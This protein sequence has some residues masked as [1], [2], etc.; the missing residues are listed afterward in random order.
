[1]CV[2]EKNIFY[3]LKKIIQR[4]GR[5]HLDSF[6]CHGF[7]QKKTS[8]YFDYVGAP[9]STV[10]NYRPVIFREIGSR[11]TDGATYTHT[12]PRVGNGVLGL[13][14]VEKLVWHATADL[15]GPFQIV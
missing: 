1:L 8:P 12:W 7:A 4:K 2:I 14:S 3:R 9:D 5:V 6:S 11:M 13:K 15:Q 10:G